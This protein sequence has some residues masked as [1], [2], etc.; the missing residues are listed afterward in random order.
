MLHMWWLLYIIYIWWCCADEEKTI[1]SPRTSR[2]NGRIGDKIR[3]GG[4]ESATGV[5]IKGGLV[6]SA[7]QVQ[8]VKSFDAVRDDATKFLD[9]FS[10]TKAYLKN[11][12]SSESSFKES[13]ESSSGFLDMGNLTVGTKVI[14]RLCI[15]NET[16]HAVKVDIR[17]TGLSETIS[18]NITSLP[19]MI[20]AGLSFY[21]YIAFTVELPAVCS[22][23]A[24]ILRSVNVLG[25]VTLHTHW[26]AEPSVTSESTF[27]IFFRTIPV[28]TRKN[29]VKIA[30][31]EAETLVQYP[32]CCP[33]SLSGL[34]DRA[35]SGK[36]QT[37]AVSSATPAIQPDTP[38]STY[39]SARRHG[40]N[41]EFI[42]H[43]PLS[44]TSS[45]RQHTGNSAVVKSAEEVRANTSAPPT[46]QAR[47]S[48]T[49]APGCNIRHPTAPT[50]TRSSSAASVSGVVKR[51]YS[52]SSKVIMK[53]KKNT[54]HVLHQGDYIGL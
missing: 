50:A 25:N 18:P 2:T 34:I 9:R 52:M 53:H 4:G 19:R 44:V 27:P 30:G 12:S 33:E 46:A 48:M 32:P 29:Q 5:P 23:N 49:S 6:I 10:D 54:S 39:S 40:E 51:R 24:H 37:S 31:L 41:T 35:H 11:K 28:A 42:D 8:A 20:A 14:I 7:G 26:P 17:A 3:G 47:V 15:T 21:A 16:A 13:N 1:T 43:F 36:R 22:A 38:Y 45:Q